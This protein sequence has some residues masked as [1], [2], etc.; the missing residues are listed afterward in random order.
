LP[1]D[2]VVPFS[3]QRPETSPSP[4]SKDICAPQQAFLPL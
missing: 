2:G 4:L 3:G 1:G